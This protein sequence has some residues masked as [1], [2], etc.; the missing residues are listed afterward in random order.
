MGVAT[1]RRTVNGLGLAVMVVLC[2]GCA[3]ARVKNVQE[4]ARTLPRPPR[5]VVFDFYTGAADV[6]VGTSPRRTARRAA[7]LSVQEP[8]LLGE[9]VANTLASR[10]VEDI[11]ALGLSAERAADALPPGP[12]DLVVQGQF[13]RVDQGSQVQ[14]FV[15]G[16]G[17]GATELRTQVEVFQVSA[18]GW[19]PVQQ[20][21]TVATGS[22]LPGAGWFVAGGAIGGTVATSAMITSGVG[23]LRELRASIDAD[24][25]RTSEQIAGKLSALKTAQLW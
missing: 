7:G 16:F 25:G 15:I 19:R 6:R 9:A 4:T 13:M 11:R 5:V 22:R 24:A 12:N 21:D 17:V 2:F 8:D 18:D 1:A 20:F 23:V 10:L 3:R 14:R